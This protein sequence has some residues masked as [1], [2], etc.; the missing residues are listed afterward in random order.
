M[1]KKE[2]VKNLR[3]VRRVYYSLIGLLRRKA[4]LSKARSV[5]HSFGF[6]SENV[7]SM[8]E[9]MLRVYRRYGFNFDEYLCYK[10]YEKSDK[11][12][13]GFVA[14]WEHLGYTCAMNNPANAAI[15]DDKWKTHNT[16]KS[17]YKRD[18]VFCQG[19]E[20][21]KSFL[22]FLEKHSRFIAKPLD[23][24]CGNGVALFEKDDYADGEALFAHMF[25]E[26]QGCFLAE[27][28]I[29]QVEELAEFHP[30]SVNTVRVPT[31]RFDDEVV[32]VHPFF[33][34][35]R[36]GKTV[37]NAGAG[38]V[39]CAVDVETGRVFAAA[40]EHAK[41][42]EIHPDTKKKIIDFVIPRWNEAKALVEELAQVVPDNRYT[43]WDLALTKDGWVLVEA[44]RRGQFVWQIPMQK[45]FRKEVNGFL[46]RLGKRY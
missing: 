30:A 11:E 45:G 41:T 18:V 32:I 38:G 20:S 24:S 3:I 1:I 28:V 9:D 34:I 36:S 37:D 2:T 5:I 40:D 43:G 21:K 8:A 33:R 35:G 15:F 16:Y 13:R 4:L 26:Y 19:E 12:R 39:I 6:S 29:V 42:Y 27:E 14:D 23:A 25:S 7:D 31:I 10:F 22:S 44:N 17:F 46:K